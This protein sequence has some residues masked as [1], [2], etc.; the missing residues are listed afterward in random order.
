MAESSLEQRIKAVRHFNRFYTRQLGLLQESYLESPY[1]LSEVR[2]LYELAHRES[3][4]AVTLAT[5]LGL[6]AGYLSRILRRFQQQ[7]LVTKQPSASDGRQLLI[8]LS[9]AGA[10]AVADL[11]RR[12]SHEIARLL[13]RT[14]PERQQH[15]V[16][17]MRTIEAV[18]DPASPPN[19]PY[20]I[21]PHRPGDLGWIVARH[22]AIY[23][24]E[25]GWDITFEAVVARIAADFIDHFDPARERCWIAE[26]D[27]V[28]I[29]SI[30]L[31][32]HP[33]R[34]GV[35]KLRLLLVEPSARGLGVGRRLVDECLRFAR[36]TG[37]Q[38]V[39]LWTYDCLTS[40]TRIY[41]SVGFRLIHE[42]PQRAFGRDLVEQTWELA[43]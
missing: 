8:R 9:D 42:S 24:E 17:A 2:V 14:P 4:P 18:L 12:S 20:L 6:D 16:A 39:T 15:L 3:T 43:L 21:R 31:V 36:Q 19:T 5:D 13:E 27:G 1:S 22:G 7:G 37:Y 35:A 41:A 38:T 23:A 10:A 33:D 11:E 32:T 28:T 26:R 29:G 40:A 25:F 34:P 30:A